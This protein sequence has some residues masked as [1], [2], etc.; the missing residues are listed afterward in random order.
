MVKSVREGF[1][2]RFRLALDEAGYGDTQLKELGAVF[3]VTP[4]AVSKWLAGEAM[5]VSERAPRVASILGVRRAWLLDNE[6]PMRPH[7]GNMAEKARDYAAAG[8]LSLSAS[9]FRLLNNYRRLPR[10]LQNSLETL[11]EGMHR[12]LK[13]GRK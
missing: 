11:V 4:Q 10:A 8:D 12:E 13:K 3:G 5:P 6:L 9:E 1:A 2:E 7:Q